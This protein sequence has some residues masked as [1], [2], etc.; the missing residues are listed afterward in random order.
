MISPPVPSF[1]DAHFWDGARAGELRV[2]RC[3]SCGTL[4]HPPAPMCA[5][6]RSTGWEAHPL[7]GL[8]TIYSWIVSRH[9]SEPDTAP[10]VVV[11]V[12]LVEGVR[13]VSNL[14]GTALD[15]IAVGLEVEAVF[16]EQEGFTLP[17]FKVVA[18]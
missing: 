4:R 16:V 15:D 5:T 2:Q 17:Q 3:T 6:C 14:I 8:G 7:S 10:R 18:S 12:E 1:D 13:V 9:P 11:L